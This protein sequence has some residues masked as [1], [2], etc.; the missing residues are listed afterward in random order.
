M[1]EFKFNII[2][3]NGLKKTVLSV[4]GD[5]TIQELINKYYENM[6]K[7]NL[8]DENI[9]NTYFIY[10]CETINYK[11]NNETV[12]KFFNGFI[13][14]EIF[15]Y[16]LEYK[17]SYRDYKKTRTIKDNI[18]TCVDEAKVYDDYLGRD[19]LVA[20]KK[21]KK[22]RLKEDIME[23]LCTTFVTKENFQSKIDR[24]NKELLYMKLLYC[25]NSVKI[26]DYYDTND[27]FVIIMELC[28]DTLLNVLANT[29]NGFSEA[30]IKEI[31][32]QL[33]NV[34]KIMH[35][36]KISHRDIKLN[37]ILVKYLN[38]EKTEFKVLLSDYGISNQLN[39]LT[40]SFKTLIGTR[41][42]MAPE[43]LRG[44]KY[45]DKCDLWSLGV[46]IY[47][48]KTKDFPYKGKV[49]NEILRQIN[50]RGQNVLNN[51]PDGQIRNL[52]S[53]LLVANP[54]ERISWDEYFQHEF[55]N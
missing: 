17:R 5:T 47:K 30:K 37:N 34:F 27:E 43:I 55:F 46:N 9:E 44:E 18:Y 11:D 24:F 49:D 8:G 36:N 14:R 13:D 50:E 45:N 41:A 33:N 38:T 16:H 28:D 2:F 29:K 21:I 35:E 53:R 26:Y 12:R 22:E 7:G 6:E 15:V 39:E 23:D 19:K 52:L 54:Q 48:L 40:T 3:N 32:L 25:E 10:N 42:I 31:L 51:I 1:E 4:K 20:V